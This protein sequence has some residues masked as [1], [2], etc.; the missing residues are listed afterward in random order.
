MSQK[1]DVK[2]LRVLYLIWMFVGMFSIMFIP[3][4]LIVTGNALETTTN[5]A[6]NSFFYSLGIAGS[7]ITQLFFI[8]VVLVLYRFF[9]SVDQKQALLMVIFAL[10]AV[11]IAMFNVINQIAALTLSKS[12]AYL[13]SFDPTQI[14]ALVMF[15][16]NLNEQGII[17]ASIFWGLWLFP[18]GFL[19]YKSGYFPKFI[20]IAL[21]IGG[22]GYL[23]G[24]FSHFLFS[25]LEI[26]LTIFDILTLGEMVFILWL[27][28][29]GA[30][31]KNKSK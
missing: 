28:F 1:K 26:L 4:K 3:S 31:L 9:K 27:I 12:P 2:L 17:I 30:K 21:I 11:P 29:F 16:L 24:S 15:F 14:Q 7:L 23:L 18:L 22:L 6:Q 13:S 8:W 5:L 25:D 19:T 20:G 10:I